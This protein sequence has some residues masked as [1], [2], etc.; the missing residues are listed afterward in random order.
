MSNFLPPRYRA[1]DANGAPISSAK[2]YFY[3]TGTT[4]P[5]ATY[6]NQGLTSANVNPVVADGS[7]YFGAIYLQEAAYRVVLKDASDVQIYSVDN[8]R[9][10]VLS[11]ADLVTRLRQVATNPLDYGAIGDGVADESAQVQ[12]AIDVAT[13]CVDLLGKTFRC[14]SGLELRSGITIRN[15]TLDFSACTGNYGLRILGTSTSRG[16]LASDVAVNATQFSVASAVGIATGDLIILSKSAVWSSGLGDSGEMLRVSSV[17]GALI[18]IAGRVRDSYAMVDGALVTELTPKTQVVVQN[19]TI[20]G[21]K[22]SAADLIL[23]DAKY[24]DGLV[25]RDCVF[26]RFKISAVRVDSCANVRIVNTAFQQGAVSSTAA[27]VDIRGASQDV[28]VGPGCQF[29]DG[30]GNGVRIGQ[31]VAT[32]D[33]V[34]RSVFV[35]G[36]AFSGCYTQAIF[37]DKMAQHAIVSGCIFEAGAGSADCVRVDTADDVLVFGCVF[38]GN[39]DGV[40]LLNSPT[41]FSQ[42]GN[43]FNVLDAPVDGGSGTGPMLSL[44]GNGTDAA[45]EA[46]GT[47]GSGVKGTAT[48]GKALWGAA[49]TG[50]GVYGTSQSS[51]AVY[52]EATTSGNGGYF[53]SAA[54]YGLVAE[55]DATSPTKAAFRIVPQDALPTGPN[56]AGDIAVYNNKLYLCTAAGTPG[57]WTIVGTQT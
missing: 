48:S 52:G 40:Y 30:G 38:R 51:N 45:I 56:A 27:F 47:T 33:W 26:I 11:N 2:L 54:G 17:V 46:T 3:E 32:N 5:L 35:T 4:T 13:G 22:T 24:A 6:S 36:C 1:A 20:I 18:S 19:L 21:S 37:I 57:T 12:A 16:G 39:D 50:Q 34:A 9:S 10:S 31:N 8:V 7:G 44:T 23:L 53:K 28:F 25:V 14:N 41:N 42:F 15:G 29:V 43:Y 49:T 55:G